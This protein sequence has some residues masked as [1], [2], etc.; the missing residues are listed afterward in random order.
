[1][2]HYICLHVIKVA[3]RMAMLLVDD[4]HGVLPFTIV[5]H[6]R[7]GL[8]SADRSRHRKLLS[9]HLHLLHMEHV[10]EL[11]TLD[12]CVLERFHLIFHELNVRIDDLR[13]LRQGLRELGDQ[14]SGPV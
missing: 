13:D 1:M 2:S 14:L 5:S 11:V 7:A 3:H 9:I 8:I 12:S 6:L 4:D 10:A